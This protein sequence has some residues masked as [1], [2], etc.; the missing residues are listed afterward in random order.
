MAFVLQL[1]KNHGKPSIRVAARIP[2]ADTVQY[3]KMNSTIYRRKTV[4]E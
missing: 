3:T 1:R 4:T 2:K